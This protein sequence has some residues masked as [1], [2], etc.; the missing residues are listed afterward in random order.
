ME[1]SDE[2]FFV[3]GVWIC[4]SFGHVKMSLF[5]SDFLSFVWSIIWI[6]VFFYCYSC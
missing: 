5:S 1:E 4:V 3:L 6:G 2:F